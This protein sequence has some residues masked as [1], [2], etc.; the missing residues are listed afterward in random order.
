MNDVII[1]NNH[2][3][4]VNEK[5]FN[6]TRE[7]IEKANEAMLHI[8]AISKNI[9]EENIE[10]LYLS[11]VLILKEQVSEVVQA[12]QM[13]KSGVIN[14]NLLDRDEIGRLIIEEDSLPYQNTIEAI[15]YGSAS[16]YSNGSTLLYVLSMPKVKPDG[17]RLLITRAAVIKGQHVDLSYKKMLINEVETFW[18]NEDWP[19]I[20]NTT[21]CS[22]KSLTKL[23]EN[24]CLARLLKGGDA[25]C[26]FEPDNTKTVEMITD[27]TIFVT[28]FEGLLQGRNYSTTLNGTYVIILNNETV[29]VGN[30][31]F[32]SR[33]VPTAQAL[34]PPLVNITIEG[35]KLNLN[36]IHGLSMENIN[37]LKQLGNNFHFSLIF[38]ALALAILAAVCYIIWRK[39]TTK[40]NFPR[41][42]QTKDQDQPSHAKDPSE[43]GAHLRDADV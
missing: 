5:L 42:N 36:Y 27:S 18:V 28:N 31:T 24:G 13:A 2:Q 35:L 15:E 38:D 9:S 29:T 34:T 17:Y 16:V 12:C 10:L 25:K 43:K 32:T 22:P 14:T 7:A 4:R 21:I 11:K 26:R 3:Y 41:L 37:Q 20:S 6:G 23:R 1:N 30:Q 19:S 39:L 40:I 33:S 8:N